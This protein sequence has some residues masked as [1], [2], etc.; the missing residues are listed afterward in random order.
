M[1]KGK[2]KF[3]GFFNL[4][5]L[6]DR[7]CINWSCGDIPLIINPGLRLVHV[8]D[9]NWHIKVL[10]ARRA[11]ALHRFLTV[12]FNNTDIRGRY[13]L[14]STSMPVLVLGVSLVI[15]G[16]GPRYKGTPTCCCSDS[17]VSGHALHAYCQ[18]CTLVPPL[19][20]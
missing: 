18:W 11:D 3:L 2:G 7:G 12:F 13:D 15:A 8:M 1:G 5:F 14:N 10:Y 17:H 9:N 16:S 19:N 6:V 20:I 4:F